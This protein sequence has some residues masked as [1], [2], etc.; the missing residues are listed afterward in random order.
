MY[1]VRLIGCEVALDD[2]TKQLGIAVA[3][4]AFGKYSCLGTEEVEA[5]LDLLLCKRSEREHLVVTC[6]SVDKH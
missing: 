4:K 3:A 1:D 5:G 2:I 6:G